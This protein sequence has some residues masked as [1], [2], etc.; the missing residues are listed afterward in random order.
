MTHPLSTG[1][2]EAAWNL[3]D[4]YHGIDDPQ[5]DAD[6]AACDAE[7][8]TLNRTY[9]GKVQQLSAAELVALLQRYEALNERI[10]RAGSFAELHWSQNTEDPAR[11][12][13]L[14]RMGERG[15][16]LSQQVIFLDLELA[17]APDDVAAA[18]LAD[19]AL[20]RWHHWLETTRIYRPYLLSEPEEKILTEKSV[21]GSS[22]WSRFFDELHSSARYVIDGEE[23]N[24]DQTL[25][26]LYH[27]D[28]QV[29]AEGAA[30]LTEGLRKML[31]T[32]T[33]IFNTLLADKASDDGLRSYPSWIAA[34]NLANEVD[35]GMV[36]ALVSAVT[37]RYD[38]VARYYTLKRRLLGLDELA[39]YDRY[40]PLPASDRFYTWDKARRIVLEAYGQFHPRMAEIAGWFFERRWIDAPPRPGK[41]GGAFSH[42]AVPSVHPYILMNFDGTPRD[43]MTLAHELGHG[44]HQRLAGVQGVLQAGTPLTTAETASVFGEMLVFRSLMAQESDPAARLALLTSTIEDAFSTSFRQISLNRFEHAVHTARREEGELPSE[45]FNEL[46]LASQR[47]MFGD[48]LT[49]TDNYGLWWSYIPHFIGTPGYVYAYAFGQLLVLALYARYQA[50]GEGFAGRYLDM[51][52]SGG[53]Q[54]PHDLVKPLGVDL[55]DPS[56]WDAGLDIL[57]SWVAE[58]E[59]LAEV[60]LQTPQPDRAG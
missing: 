48:S 30:A 59:T 37:G 36:D 29:R 21:T 10:G 50:H 47:A 22:A 60:V 43:V 7:A 26:R 40:A 2:E 32:T 27:P 46:W 55:T 4:L 13:L 44:V 35:E 58:A 14:Q 9:R 34:R 56:F 15:S 39:D 12:A 38:L 19:P 53:S 42:G 54:W 51:L 41:L 11:G 20:Q 57:A 1:A 25:T 52:A 33:F 8:A 5:I 16:K 45:R 6:L 24:Q 17:A 23:L 49:I 31:R 3:D 28:R 18:W